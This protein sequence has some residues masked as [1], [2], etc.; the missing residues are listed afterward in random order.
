MDM[1]HPAETLT[2]QDGRE[3]II[4]SAEPEDAAGMLH[5]MKI[6]LGETPFLL[7]TPEEFNYTPEEE[8]QILAGRKNDPR[9]LMLVAETGGRIIASADVCSHGSKSRVR[10]RAE[11]GISVRKDYW[12]QGIGSVLMERLVSFAKKTDFEQIELTVESK[13][14]RALRLYLKNGFMVYGTRPHGM[15][16]PDGSYDNDYLMIRM[17]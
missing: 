1:V 2:L 8:A 10:H 12:H 5:Y 6:M 13:N 14:Q 11:L 16:Y 7:R 4:R 3:I 17:L 9:S 15:K